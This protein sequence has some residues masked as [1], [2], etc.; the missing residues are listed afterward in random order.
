[1]N[2]CLWFSLF[3]VLHWNLYFFHIQGVVDTA[4][5][6][7]GSDHYEDAY[8]DGGGG[9]DD[10]DEDFE[11]EIKQLISD[12]GVELGSKTAKASK[13]PSRAAATRKRKSEVCTICV[14]CVPYFI[15]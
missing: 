9:G 15:M 6:D 3:Y 8:D 4:D 12:A 2:I 14:H 5:D 11:K 1:M 10:D 7:A 13:R